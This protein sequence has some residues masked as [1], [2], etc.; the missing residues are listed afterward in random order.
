[1]LVTRINGVRVEIRKN[2]GW[3][4]TIPSILIGRNARPMTLF[5]A[6]LKGLLYRLA[7]D[8]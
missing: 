5:D 6:S 8:L 3:T 4:A 1:M 7:L 2:V